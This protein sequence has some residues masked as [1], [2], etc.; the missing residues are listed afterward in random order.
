MAAENHMPR[1]LIVE[2]DPD[3]CQLLLV[4]LANRRYELL[5][6]SDGEQAITLAHAYLPDLIVMDIGLPRING[7]TATF[8]LK[9]ARATAHIPVL[10]LTAHIWLTDPARGA[11]ALFDAIV[12]KPFEIAVLR[13]HVDALLAAG[14]SRAVGEGAM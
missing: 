3:I 11:S 4:V 7:L 6:A 12:T 5:V 10:A 9:A 2:D 13:Q 8:R 14:R 1:I